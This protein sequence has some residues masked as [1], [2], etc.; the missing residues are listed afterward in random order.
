MS[1]NQEISMKNIKALLDAQK[2]EI[3]QAINTSLS[4]IT[5]DI[6]EL[7][8]AYTNIKSTVQKNTDDI[9]EIRQQ[10]LNLTSDN[11][12]FSEDI[13]KLSAALDDQVN[14][15][16]RKTLIFK[17][18]PINTNKSKESWSDT[19]LTIADTIAKAANI[20]PKNAH[21]MI[22]RCHRGKVNENST[23]SSHIFVKFHK[24]ADSEH[25]KNIFFMSKNNIRVEQMYSPSLTRRRNEAM[26]ERRRLIENK[27]IVSGYLEY[28][29]L[30]KVK[31]KKEDPRYVLLKSF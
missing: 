21:D 2:K 19:K 25:T 10:L 30:L 26:K 1:I 31:K 5:S 15:N 8:I 13:I 16:L 3:L 14:R 6:A 23:K 28:P 18:I 27:S 17:N 4:K 22:E 29:A 24:W 20:D 7:K 11:K 9:N 12:T